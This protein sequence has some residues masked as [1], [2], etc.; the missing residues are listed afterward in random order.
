VK[1]QNTL[2]KLYDNKAHPNYKYLDS[3]VKKII[4]NISKWENF[5]HG[6]EHKTL[7]DVGKLSMAHLGNRL[8]TKLKKLTEKL[9]ANQIEVNV[10]YFFLFMDY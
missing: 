1:F 8:N 9:Q 6:A 4:R 10:T 7:N 5:L 2:K 3:N